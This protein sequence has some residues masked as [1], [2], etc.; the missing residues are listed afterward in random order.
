MAAINGAALVSILGILHLLGPAPRFQ[1]D[2]FWVGRHVV[3]VR[4]ALFALM[5]AAACLIVSILLRTQRLVVV[6]AW[7]LAATAGGWM[8]SDRIQVIAEQVWAR[9]SG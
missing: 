6:G 2:A 1:P 9:F 4:F 5:V 3:S 7:A 8:F